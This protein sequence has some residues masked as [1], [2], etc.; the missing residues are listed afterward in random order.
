MTENIYQWIEHPEL[1][2]KES[3][4]ELRNLLGRYP[5]FQCIRLLYLKNLYLLGE[6]EFEEELH[7]SSI[8][9]NERKVLYSMFE[10]YIP[11]AFESKSS[12]NNSDRI[13]IKKDDNIKA[14]RTEMLIDAFLSCKEEDIEKMKL[15]MEVT[16]DYASFLM[17]DEEQT[18]EN[19]GT[20]EM[21][22]QN[23]IDNFV[24]QAAI[25]EDKEK[26]EEK[27][28]NEYGSANYNNDEEKIIDNQI[29]QADDEEESYFTETL[30]KIYIKQQRY[31]KAI[32]IIKKLNLKYPKKNAYFADQIRF[33]EK[34]IINTKSK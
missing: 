13:L 24:K 23:L 2:N 3:L 34:L 21:K 4:Y 32:E 5:Y 30:A 17:K 26:Q 19:G 22:G 9:I 12:S 31:S 15:S 11:A 20:V 14:N 16:T 7:K 1:L 10:G 6:N 27:T 25:S 33:L 28:D 8:Y 29:T 18:E